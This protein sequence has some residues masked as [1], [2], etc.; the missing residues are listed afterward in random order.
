MPEKVRVGFIGSGGMAE[1]HLRGLPTFPDVEI[2]SFCDVVAAKAEKLA[3]EYGAKAF[4]DPRQ[5]LSA[6]K[7]DCVY[8]L[9]PPFAHGEAEQAA[10]EAKVPFF[11]E[12]PIGMDIP[13]LREIAS[14]VRAA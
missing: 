2:A 14:G 5:M 12:K 4:S 7:L 10:I 6:E 13:V 8:I 1:A 3:A 11:V 9:L